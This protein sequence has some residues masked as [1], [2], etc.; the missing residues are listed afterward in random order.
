MQVPPLEAVTE[1]L[2]RG[3]AKGEVAVQERPECG[4][5]ARRKSR[6]I[7]PPFWPPRSI[8]FAGRCT[9][10]L[11]RTCQT[12]PSAMT[13]SRSQQS[14]SMRC[15]RVVTA[16]RGVPSAANHSSSRLMFC[17]QISK[18]PMRAPN[19]LSVM[20]Q[21]TSTPACLDEN[22]KHGGDQKWTSIVLSGRRSASASCSG[23]SPAMRNCSRDAC[24]VWTLPVS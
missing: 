10:S 2:S 17:S 21:R 15:S 18:S 7:C 5:P 11:R 24:P 13:R 8:S 22:R 14:R 20:P 23:Q 3:S 19:D 9:C 12:A 1:L 16:L 4:A 6:N